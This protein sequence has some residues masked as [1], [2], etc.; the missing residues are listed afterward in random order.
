MNTVL[1]VVQPVE[2]RVG[3]C[4][5]T[6]VDPQLWTDSQ[7]YVTRGYC[8]HYCLLCTNNT[9][10]DTLIPTVWEELSRLLGEGVYFVA[11]V[12]VCVVLTLQLSSADCV[13]YLALQEL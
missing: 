11:F 12:R 3:L 8:K 9:P 13:S 2:R 4:G 10:G 7:V 1:S 6:L 5:R